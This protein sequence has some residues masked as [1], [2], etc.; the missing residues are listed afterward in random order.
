[1]SQVHKNYIANEWVA[2]ESVIENINPSDTS[3]IVGEYAQASDADIS[4]LFRPHKKVLMLGG[5]NHSLSNVKRLLP[6]LGVS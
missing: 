1:M 5:E 6:L 2:G 4:L 3:K